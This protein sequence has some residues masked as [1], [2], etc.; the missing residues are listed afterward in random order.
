MYTHTYHLYAYTQIYIY[1]YSHIR[2]HISTRTYAYTNKYICTF[3]DLYMYS[4]YLC[5]YKYNAIIQIMKIIINNIVNIV[6]HIKFVK[7]LAIV[8]FRIFAVFLGCLHKIPT[9]QPPYPYVY[10]YMH[11]EIT[12]NFGF[13]HIILISHGTSFFERSFYIYLR[14]L[15]L[16]IALNMPSS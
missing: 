4:M 12:S 10:I 15:S 6:N 2:I 8:S 3:G 1:T 5:I 14:I 13:K 7:H 11:Q 16:P 9:R